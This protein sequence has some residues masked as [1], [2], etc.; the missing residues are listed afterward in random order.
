MNNTRPMFYT[1]RQMEQM[2]E[3]RLAREKAAKIQTFGKGLIVGAILTV[4]LLGVIL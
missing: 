1:A 3:R 4:L 2:R